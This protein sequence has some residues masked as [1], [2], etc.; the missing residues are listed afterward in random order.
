M[1]VLRHDDV[2]GNHK[3]IAAAYARQRIFEKL[4]GRSR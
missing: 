1:N 2:S 3:E 4:H